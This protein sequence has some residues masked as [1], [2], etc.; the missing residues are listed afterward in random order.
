[1]RD[2]SQIYM[3][4]EQSPVVE[5]GSQRICNV[6]RTKE[7]LRRNLLHLILLIIVLPRWH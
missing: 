2:I 6:R 1:M 4:R 3:V 5:G 7:V